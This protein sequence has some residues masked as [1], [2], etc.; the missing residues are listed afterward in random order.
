[1]QILVGFF[2]VKKQ[3]LSLGLT[4]WFQRI[5]VPLHIRPNGLLLPAGNLNS[6]PLICDK[7]KTTK[8]ILIIKSES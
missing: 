2:V 3:N 6:G 5:E 4:I 7:K 1:M 8:G